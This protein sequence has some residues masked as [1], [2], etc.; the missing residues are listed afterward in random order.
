MPQ[1]KLERIRA[2]LDE[3]AEFN[4]HDIRDIQLTKDDV[5][6]EIPA[7][8]IEKWRFMGLSNKDFVNF[9]FWKYH[10]DIG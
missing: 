10:G 1:Y 2:L 6:M 5:S 9:E 3:L 4:S 7:E 8:V